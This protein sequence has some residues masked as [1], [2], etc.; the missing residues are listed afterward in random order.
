MYASNYIFSRSFFTAWIIV[1][2]IWLWC[3]LFVVGFFPIID[4]RGQILQIWRALRTGQQQ[5]AQPEH[6]RSPA[7]S[8]FGSDTSPAKKDALYDEKEVGTPLSS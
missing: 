6:E 2:I 4:G 1:A 7:E 8:S 5:T 3:T